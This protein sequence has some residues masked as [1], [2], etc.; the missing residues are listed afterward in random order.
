MPIKLLRLPLLALAGAILG[1]CGMLSR[2]PGTSVVELYNHSGRTVLVE[3]NE[4][5]PNR[6]GTFQYPAESGKP[7]IV[8]WHGCVHT[9]IAPERAP[10]EF[11]G[12]DW[13]F[14]GAYRTQLEPDGKL[15][16]VPTGS[17]LPGDPATMEQPQGFPLSPREGS[18]CLD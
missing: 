5:R 10:G 7:L 11:R 3:G 14:R 12:T 13:M 18:T 6:A 9:Y 4:L 2:G 8:F 17:D 15:Y 16:L 1:S